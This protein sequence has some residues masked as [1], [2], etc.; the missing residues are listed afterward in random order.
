MCS[1]DL[2]IAGNAVVLKPDLQST[3]SAVW[4]ADLFRQAGLPEGIFTIVAGEGG[5]VGPMVIDRAD[6]VM[7]TGSTQVGRLVASRCGE[8]LIGCS[9][10]LG[11]KNAMIIRADA[12]MESAASIA[13]RASFSNSGQLCISMERIYVPE[14][15]F[16]DFLAAFERRTRKLRMTATV[17]WGSDIGSLIS[18]QQLTRVREHVQQA[19]DQGAHVV[20]GGRARPD[21]GPYF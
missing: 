18:L 11:G 3:L 12:D 9:M 20:C 19:V 8:R 17:G 13:V 2:L 15:R 14:N 16:D 10:E 21:I 6:Y 5:D 7:F 4:V 1:S